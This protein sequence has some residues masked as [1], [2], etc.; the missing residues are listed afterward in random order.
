MP[1]FDIVCSLGFIEHFDNPL[2]VVA[3]HTDLLKPGGILMIGVP[4]LGGIYHLFLKHLSPSHDITHNLKIMDL[5]NWNEIERKLDLATVFKGYIG[6]FE[7]MIM[8][9]LDEKSGFNQFLLF[10]V[11]V[12]MIIF[13]FRMRFLR[14][15]NSRYWSGYLIGIYRKG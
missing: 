13:S 10:I 6:G 5:K 7:P 11:K 8:K 1:K 4:N 15:F 9:K 3:R 12:L 14:K 2:S